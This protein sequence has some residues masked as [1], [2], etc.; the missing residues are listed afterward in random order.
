M[1]K[2]IIIVGGI[3]AL[4]FAVLAV[5]MIMYNEPQTDTNSL[6]G[7]KKTITLKLTEVADEAKNWVPSNITLKKGDSVQ[8]TIVNGDD[9]VEH[10][11]AV[12]DLGL[13]SVSIPPVNGRIT[14]QF[15][16]DKTG[17]FK[18]IDPSVPAWESPDCNPDPEKICI[19][20][21]KIIVEP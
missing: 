4:I 17:I 11:F 7:G 2:K 8:L 13:E 5:Y 1:D 16:A 12:P 3:M 10:K 18:F 19:P 6:S 21:G 20:P 9:D 14:M 15:N